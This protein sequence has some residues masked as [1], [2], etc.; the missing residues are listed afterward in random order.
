MSSGLLS[1]FTFSG[2]NPVG[3]TSF[4]ESQTSNFFSC[5]AEFLRSTH[6]S[7]STV[8]RSLNGPVYFKVKLTTDYNE[9][10][11]TVLTAGL[12]KTV[13]SRRSHVRPTVKQCT[14]INSN[15]WL[16]SVLNLIDWKTGSS[17]LDQSQ[18]VVRKNQWSPFSVSNYF[19][20]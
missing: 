5:I 11:L 2:V 4:V 6:R 10:V 20:R 13:F 17:F 19:W 3:R 14:W 15:E 1:I 16:V 18:S 9:S 8:Q 7:T 12:H